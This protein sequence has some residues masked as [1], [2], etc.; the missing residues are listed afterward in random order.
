MNYD[1]ALLIAS[2]LND[3]RVRDAADCAVKLK[4][5]QL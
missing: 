5:A 1:A 2:I 4:L 3:D